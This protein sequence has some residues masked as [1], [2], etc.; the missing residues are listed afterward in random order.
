VV[1]YLDTSA[2]VKLYIRE[3]EGVELVREAVKRS[4]RVATSTVAYAEAR[5]GLARKR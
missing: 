4:E 3:E 5:A 1:V 2:L